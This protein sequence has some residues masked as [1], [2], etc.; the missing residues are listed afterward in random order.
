M[1]VADNTYTITASKVTVK[2]NDVATLTKGYT[3]I[4][5]MKKG[6]TYSITEISCD[7]GTILKVDLFAAQRTVL[8]DSTS[9]RITFADGKMNIREDYFVGSY[10]K[11]SSWG[12]IWWIILIIVVVVIVVVAIVW[13]LIATLCK[14]K[15]LRKV[16]K[17]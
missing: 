13:V 4:P 6:K 15:N 1:T 2:S 8:K 7:M 17:K 10:T 11:T 3:C 9:T 16:T 14:S 12:S 5:E